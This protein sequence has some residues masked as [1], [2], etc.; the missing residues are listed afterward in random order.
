MLNESMPHLRFSSVDDVNGVVLF[1][2]SAT[3]GNVT[4]N[5]INVDGG[6]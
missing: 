4:G 6:H 1:L 5:V 2:A 3:N